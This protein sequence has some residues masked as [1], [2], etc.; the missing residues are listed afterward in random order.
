MLEEGQ[1]NDW[2]QSGYIVALGLLALVA[3]V[4]FVVQ[5]L[6]TDAPAV[7][8]GVLKDR[9]FS[10]ATVIGG[11]LGVGIGEFFDPRAL[12]VGGMT[13]AVIFAVFFSWL[14]RWG[15]RALI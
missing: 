11:M 3:L 10:S 5:E 13:G 15:S 2:F 14:Y 12:S 1:S 7:S 4:L 6:Q 9:S 8:L